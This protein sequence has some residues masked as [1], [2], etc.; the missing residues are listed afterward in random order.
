MVTVEKVNLMTQEGHAWWA[1]LRLSLV[2]GIE[3]PMTIFA[4]VLDSLGIREAI[5][6]DQDGYPGILGYKG[7]AL[8][9]VAGASVAPIGDVIESMM[10]RKSDSEIAL[11]RD[12]VDEFVLPEKS[13]YG[14]ILLRFLLAGFDRDRQILV[15]VKAEAYKGVRD[16]PP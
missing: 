5:G 16:G 9:D 12:D 6:A 11:I 13:L 4:R 8:S 14:R 7:P 15:A 1:P 10:A 3:H 2:P